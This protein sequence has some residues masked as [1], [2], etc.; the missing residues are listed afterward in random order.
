MRIRVFSILMALCIA[1]GGLVSLTGCGKEEAATEQQGAGE[2]DAAYTNSLTGEGSDEE[3]PARP[4][5]VSIDNVGDAVPQS[6]LSKADMVYE[7]PVEGG[8][9]R[10][11]AIYYGEFPEEFGP[12]RSA[13]PYFIDLTREY[14]GVFLAHGWSED[15]KKY[16]MTGAVPYINAMNSDLKFYRSPKKTSPHD[17]YIKW[18]EVESKIDKEGWWDEK[19]DIE[20]FTFLSAGEPV[21]GDYAGKVYFKNSSSK[22]EFTYDSGKNTYTRT[23]DGK[24]YIDIETGESIET[25]NVLVQKVRSSVLD[26]KGRLKINL[27]A[28]GEAMLFTNGKVIEGTWSRAGLDDRTVFTDKDGNQFKLGVGTTWVEVADQGCGITYDPPEEPVEALE[29]IDSVRAATQALAK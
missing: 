8:Q 6:W 27:C 7:F 13:R 10:L 25:T 3:L 4:L 22:C 12:I 24:K 21:A 14:K 26:S 18:S 29:L 1:A 5:I 20:P 28:G 23:I 17:S 2:P 16:L 19:Q 15:A 9:T 11:Q